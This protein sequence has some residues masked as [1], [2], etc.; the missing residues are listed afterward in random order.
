MTGQQILTYEK[1]KISV[2]I[3][4]GMEYTVQVS[5]MKI[6]GVNGTAVGIKFTNAAGSMDPA[7]GGSV[8]FLKLAR[9][10]GGKAAQMILQDIKNISIVGFY[11]LTEDLAKRSDTAVAAK[12]RAYT[13][14]ARLIH[15][16]L[17]GYL[18]IL[19]MYD[20]DGGLG[21]TMSKKDLEQT[22]ELDLFKEELRKTLQVIPC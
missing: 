13:S 5:Y 22:N 10:I 15:K 17:K 8:S 20:S 21:W 14:G 19:T 12:Q 2:T 3:V 11:L 1:E 9:A 7:K 6:Q 18:P 4:N 16:D